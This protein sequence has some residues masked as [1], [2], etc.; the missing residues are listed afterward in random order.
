MDE[1]ARYTRKRLIATLM[2]WRKYVPRLNTM[3]VKEHLSNKDLVL[4]GS[5]GSLGTILLVK[6]YNIQ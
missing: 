1:I 5:L 6:R 3:E 4:K 2:K